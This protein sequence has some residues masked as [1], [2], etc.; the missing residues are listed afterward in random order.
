MKRSELF[1]SILLVPLDFLSLLLAAY[2]AHRIRFLAIVEEIRPVLYDIPTVTYLRSVIWIIIIWLIIFAVAGLYNRRVTDTWLSEFGR[3]FF[4][5]STGLVFIIVAVFLWRELFS[6]RFIILTGWILSI[7]FVS[8]TRLV[9]R[10]IQRTLFVFGYGARRVVVVGAS[11]IT[12]EVIGSLNLHPELG[13]KVVES[14]PSVKDSLLR[15]YEL[16]QIGAIDEI[17]FIDLEASRE[18]RAEF[19]E[20]AELNHVTFR[21]TPDLL[22]SPAGNPVLDLN[23]GVPLIE[24]PETNIVGWNRIIKRFFDIIYS[25]VF[26][27]ILSP[28]FVIIAILIA[29]DDGWPIIY[30]SYRVGRGKNFVFYKFRSMK[31]EC[32]QGVE[33]GGERADNLYRELMSKQ[34]DRTGPVPK[35]IN[36]PRITKVGYWIRRFSMDELPQLFNVLIGEMSLVGPRPHLPTEVASYEKHHQKVLAI[37][38]GLTGLAQVSGRSDLDFEDEVRLDRYYIEQWS[39][40]LD[41]KIIFKTIPAIIKPRKAL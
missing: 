4:A 8:V 10:H 1:F 18:L 30:K 39:L 11:H 24:V 38:P 27:I 21:Y 5:C 20:F 41:F 32:C 31:L 34:R 14:L 35:I 9:I 29:L 33:Y 2:V 19:L 17:H 6:S 36:D 22:A 13:Y 7:V 12:T 40:M 16:I 15:L 37:K 3:I 28:L 26:M 25:V 23:I